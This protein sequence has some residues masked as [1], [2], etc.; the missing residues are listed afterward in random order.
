M[1]KELL[2]LKKQR[3]EYEELIRRQAEDFQKE[4]EQHKFSLA[5]MEAVL[6]SKGEKNILQ[7]LNR[8]LDILKPHSKDRQLLELASTLADMK[9]TH[10]QEEEA[11]KAQVAAVQ[12]SN[13]LLHSQTVDLQARLEDSLAEST[14][15]RALLTP[16]QAT[17]HQEEQQAQGPT[18]ESLVKE[19]DLLKQKVISLRKHKIEARQDVARIS[20]QLV[21]EKT[22]REGPLSVLIF[23]TWLPGLR[24]LPQAQRG[25]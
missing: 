25:V 7:S 19:N 17:T 4:R 6:E 18:K 16:E 8:K 22:Q 2:S 21:E 12:A 14:K 5:K 15:L 1:Q 11:L 3:Y 10:E 24:A 9:Q 20:L 13:R 23:R